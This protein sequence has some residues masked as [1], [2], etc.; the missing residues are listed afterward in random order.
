M[1]FAK[2]KSSNFSRNMSRSLHFSHFSIDLHLFF[3]IILKGLIVQRH[4]TL[5]TLC[6]VWRILLCVRSEFSIVYFQISFLLLS[7][8]CSCLIYLC[9]FSLWKVKTTGYTL[10]W[11]QFRSRSYLYFSLSISMKH[12]LFSYIAL[13]MLINEERMTYFADIFQNESMYMDA[14]LNTWVS[15]I[16][17]PESIVHSSESKYLFATWSTSFETC[18]LISSFLIY[19][20]FS[21]LPIIKNKVTP[22]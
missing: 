11:L 18:L 14:F 13:K 1:F 7:S 6:R 5:C 21:S 16:E 12:V 9:S 17:V 8:N 22:C 4:Y 2:S 10:V 3:I 20:I 19:C 15:E